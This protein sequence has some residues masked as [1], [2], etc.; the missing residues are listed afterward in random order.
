MRSE[1][2]PPQA[3][4]ED[5]TVQPL[6]QEDAIRARRSVARM[7]ALLWCLVTPGALLLVV[8]QATWS[9]AP[10]LPAALRSVRLEQWVGIA[11]IVAHLWFILQSLRR[12]PPSSRAE[13]HLPGD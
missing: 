2:E 5:P 1:T 12:L 9:Q 7:R 10:D 13:T 4:Q 8:R 3:L 11:L 6:S